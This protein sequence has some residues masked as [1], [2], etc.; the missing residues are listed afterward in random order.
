MTDRN[1][2]LRV[3][4]LLEA[5]AKGY[6]ELGCEDDLERVRGAM[7]RVYWE[8][9]TEDDHAWLNDR[10]GGPPSDNPNI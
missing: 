9:L 3:Y 7:D 8:V 1:I 10:N 4:L 6:E 2:P 5:A